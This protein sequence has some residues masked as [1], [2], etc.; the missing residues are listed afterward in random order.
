MY[1]QSVEFPITIFSLK[2]LENSWKH[3]LEEKITNEELVTNC[4][5]ASAFLTYCGPMTS[6]ARKRMT[7]FYTHVCKHYELP[8]PNKMLFTSQRYH[9]LNLITVT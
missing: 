6:D 9:N 4:V 7:S 1:L 2:P 8:I 3:E 5:L